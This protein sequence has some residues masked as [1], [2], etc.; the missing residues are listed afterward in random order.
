[1][2]RLQIACS[3]AVLTL[4]LSVAG[5][6]ETASGGA[7]AGG[8]RADAGS[9]TVQDS[10][11]VSD[12]GRADAGGSVT[13]AGSTTPIF[14]N[15]Q[16]ASF[17]DHKADA[18]TTVMFGGELGNN[19]SPR[20]IVITTGHGV[21]YTGPFQFHPLSKGTPGN[22]SAGSASSPIA[23]TISGT[24]ATFTFPTEGEFPFFC[25]VHGSSGMNGVVR[26]RN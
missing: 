2:R 19:Y 26:V 12:A 6:G 5:C 3:S 25:T 4:A 13:D 10:G 7:D 1:M 23:S 21:A 20:C 9:N 18:T 16:E 15:C 22:T 14:N 17:V 24:A 11:T 8:P